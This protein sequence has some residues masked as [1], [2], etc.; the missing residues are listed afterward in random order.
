MPD[1]N[2]IAKRIEDDLK[3]VAK[4]RHDAEEEK[5]EMDEKVK[6]DAEETMNKVLSCLD[7]LSS[8]FDAFEAA[9]KARADAAKKKDAEGEI[10]RKGDPVESSVD[11]ARADSAAIISELATIQSFADRADS[12]WSKSAPAPWAG[13]MP[14]NYRRRLAATHKKHSDAWR[15]CDLHDLKSTALRNAC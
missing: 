10:E 2:E 4:A 15:D 5:K 12:A 3:M 7:S 11:S 14:D 9:D 13:E 8:R 1:P 6:S